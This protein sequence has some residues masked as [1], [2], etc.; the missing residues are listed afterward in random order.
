MSLDNIWLITILSI[1]GAFIEIFRR[2]TS[3]ARLEKMQRF[4][5]S[6]QHLSSS[7]PKLKTYWAQLFVVETSSEFLGIACAHAVSISYLLH[8]SSSWDEVSG[9]ISGMVASFFV[10]I[11]VEF[12]ADIICS[13]YELTYLKIPLYNVW[14]LDWK[15]VVFLTLWFACATPD[16]AQESYLT[17][18]LAEPWGPNIPSTRIC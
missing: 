10:Q 1:V 8:Y 14:L 16:L 9:A 11:A 18:C 4:F 17:F 6:R 2:L 13:C 12:A 5:C 3:V 7:N 15:T